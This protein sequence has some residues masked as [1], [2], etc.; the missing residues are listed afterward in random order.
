MYTALPPYFGAWTSEFS[1]VMRIDPDGKTGDVLKPVSGGPQIWLA[2][3]G[4][5]TMLYN[6][7]AT[8]TTDTLKSRLAD[9][10]ALVVNQTSSVMPLARA[11]ISGLPSW[12]MSATTT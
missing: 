4:V 9:A 10:R 3:H 11:T 8:E 1:L 12:L 5:H 2:G 6:A 7:M